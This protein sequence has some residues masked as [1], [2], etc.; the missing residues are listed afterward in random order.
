MSKLIVCISAIALFITACNKKN[1]GNLVPVPDAPTA[2]V[3]VVNASS[4]ASTSDMFVNGV[5]A[6][7]QIIY[8]FTTNYFAIN[9]DVNGNNKV[10]F[11]KANTKDT[12]S[13]LTLKFSANNYYTITLTD[14]SG[15]VTNAIIA[16][17]AKI[18]NPNK[19]YVR[20]FYLSSDPGL[21]VSMYALL[22]VFLN[23]STSTN[24]AFDHRGFN[25]HNKQ[26]NPY[27]VTK[28]FIPGQYTIHLL[29]HFTG[30]TLLKNIPITTKAGML[31][32]ISL[33]GSTGTPN[34]VG[35]IINEDK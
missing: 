17:T 23:T 35:V 7:A 1:D 20:F 18:A 22:D 26:S 2:Y 24:R 19:C 29:S 28:E 34:G 14:S 30:D 8:P 3:K 21:V 4:N 33:Y 25:D 6:K 27:A 10:V 5:L 13:K 15:F 32:T 9:P 31:Y 16:D 11:F 12:L